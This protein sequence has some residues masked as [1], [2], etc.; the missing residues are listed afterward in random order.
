MKVSAKRKIANVIQKYALKEEVKGRTKNDYRVE[1]YSF[2]KF[3]VEKEILVKK[4]RE[5]VTERVGG[6]EASRRR[7]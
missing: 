5:R 4:L 3:F 1:K 7:A 6:R 2:Y